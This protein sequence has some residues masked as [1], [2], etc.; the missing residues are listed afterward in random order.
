VDH[1][2]TDP[3]WRRFYVRVQKEA[4]RRHGASIAVV[5]KVVN[6]A[7]ICELT[8]LCGSGDLH[9]T[10]EGYRRIGKLVSNVAGLDRSR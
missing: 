4:A 2:E 10:D 7:N 9:P 3:L 8:F 1:P 5:S 6:R